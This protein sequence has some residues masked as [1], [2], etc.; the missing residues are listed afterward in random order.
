MNL[1][2]Q[3]IGHWIERA[4]QIATA[5]H[6]EQKR[7]NGRPYIE[8][9]KRVA[10]NV[11][12]RLKPIAWLH[13]TIEDHPEKI[14][15]EDL[16]TEGFPTYILEAVDLLTHRKGDTN[17]AYWKKILTNPDAV[18]VKLRDIHD[19]MSETPSDYAREKYGRA[20]H[21]FKQAGYSL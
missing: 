12:D 18:N 3:T 17:M 21:L 2:E 6:S 8:H 16:K 13:D 10:D 7:T 19:N 20:L 4:E 1:S 15:L 14:S 9:C 11:E 5:I